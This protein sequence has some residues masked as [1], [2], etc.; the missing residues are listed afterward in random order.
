MRKDLS[1]LEEPIL[2]Y[3]DSEGLTTYSSDGKKRAILHQIS[4]K[5]IK[6]STIPKFKE[7]VSILEIFQNQQIINQIILNEN[8]SNFTTHPSISNSLAFSQNDKKLCFTVIDKI[9]LEKES[10]LGYKTKMFEYKDFGEICVK[11][12]Y[13]LSLI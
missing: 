12:I 2:S 4:H 11:Y 3:N 13:I 6:S 8:Y 7:K 9:D 5:K 10:I 1:E